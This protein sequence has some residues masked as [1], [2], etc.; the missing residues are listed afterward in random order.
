MKVGDLVKLRHPTTRCFNKVFLV[1]ERRK[2]DFNWVKVLGH[3][4]LSGWQRITDF[5]VINESR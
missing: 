3:Y 5:E 4:G 2:G 1:T